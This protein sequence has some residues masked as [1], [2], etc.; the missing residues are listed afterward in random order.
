MK[1][2]PFLAL[3]LSLA[4]SLPAAAYDMGAPDTPTRLSAGLAHT[5]YV[6]E[7]GVLW[8]WGSN[9]A[10][11]LGAETQETGTGSQGET[12]PLSTVPLR[13]MEDV[14][15]ASA[16]ADFTLALKA[17]GTLWAWGGNDYGQLGNG[18]TEPALQPVQILDQVAAVSAGDYYA[19]A[20]RTDGTLWTWG[21]NL[22]GQLGDGTLHSRTTPTLVL[23]QVTAVSAGVG[24]T[25]ALRSD[26]TLWTWGDNLFGQ[27]GDGTLDSRPLP[28]QILDNV[29][30]VSMGGYHALALRTG[31]TL[32]TW[33]SSIDGQLGLGDLGEDTAPQPCPTQVPIEEGPIAQISAGTSHSAVI[34]SDGRL[35]AWGRNH[36]NQLG[37][38]GAEALAGP[39]PVS[40][41]TG[42]AAVATGTYH[43]ACLLADGTLLAWGPQSLLGGGAVEA[44]A[45]LAVPAEATQVLFHAGTPSYKLPLSVL[46]GSAALMLLAGLLTGNRRVRG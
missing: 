24:A 36:S 8:A 3:V 20:L 2:F 33:G 15:S 14:V 37:Q 5:V 27:L 34:L 26:G 30:A 4:L 28:R 12:I 29:T 35:L 38:P 31:G 46:L 9:Q 22:Y 6:D 40:G 10:G 23:T 1:R 39:S 21:D 43:T 44:M 16:G 18:T 32:W 19:A 45:P 42:A 17:D 7:D 41:V 13:V 11:Q 25:A